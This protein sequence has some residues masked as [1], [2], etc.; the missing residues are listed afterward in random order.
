M[1]FWLFLI[2]WRKHVDG[3][4]VDGSE[5]VQILP[6]CGSVNDSQFEG[7]KQNK[8]A[9]LDVKYRYVR[10]LILGNIGIVRAVEGVYFNDAVV[11]FLFCIG[12]YDKLS[13]LNLRHQCERF[14][15]ELDNFYPIIG[16]SL[17]QNQPAEGN[18]G[19]HPSRRECSEIFN[20]NRKIHG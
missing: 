4:F 11:I 20:R 9:G 5:F 15:I 18:I 16:M 8:M 2:L 13:S 19:Y 6:C 14:S 10:K 12:V 3:R 7:T 1:Y 17:A